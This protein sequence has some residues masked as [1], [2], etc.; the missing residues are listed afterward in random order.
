MSYPTLNQLEQDLKQGCLSRRDFIKAAA[1]F[2][3]SVSA[4]GLLSGQNAYAAT[5]K[6]GGHFKIA[7]GHGSTT[8][9][10]DPALT[11]SQFTQM[12]CKSIHNYLT[13]IRADGS[14]GP[15]LAVGWEAS[16][17][18]KT[19]T[20]KLRKGVEFHNG[21]TL[22]AQDVVASLNYHGGKDSKSGAKVIVDEFQSITAQGE[23]ELVIELKEGNA[24]LT[25][26]LSDFHLVIM[27]TDQDGKLNPVSGVGCG[28]YVLKDFEPGVKAELSKFERHW[29]EKEGHFASAEILSVKD[30]AARTNALRTGEVDA[31]DRLDIKTLSLLER[32]ESI[33]IMETSGN[34]HY[35]M[36]MRCDTDPFKDNNIRLALKHCIDRETMLETLLRGHGYVGNDHP[37]GRANR[38]FAA[39]LE[40]RSYDPERAKHYLKQA[41]VDKLKVQLSAAE[42]AFVGAVDAAVLYRENAAKAGIEVE[43]IREADDGYWSDVW[44]KKPWSMCYWN[45]R[46]T[47]DMMFSTTYVG[48]AEW[49]DSFWQ[50]ERFDTLVKEARSELNEDKRTEM[51][52][53]AQQ[54]VSNDGGVGIPVFN[55]YLFASHKGIGQPEQLGNDMDVDGLRAIVRWWRTG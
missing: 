33:H 44:M 11:A 19:W 54:I 51:Y 7:L 21:K 8:D 40:Q 50:N 46:P 2:G 24:D 53:E 47:E 18:A 34:S 9:S 15:E 38:Y 49:N 31:I 3:L 55:N 13:E 37:I 52:A 23:D 45:G 48:D 35:S 12:L 16:A 29:N 30:T 42:A 32:D 1:L 28:S 27:P 22:T 25:Y 6:A 10:L 5:P 14:L 43:V 17:D 36:P 41:G 39:D 26:Q 4:P 20:F